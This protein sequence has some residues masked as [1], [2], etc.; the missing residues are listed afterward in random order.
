MNDQ[1]CGNCKF[2]ARD[3]GN[4]KQ[5]FCRLRPPA[6]FPVPMQQVAGMTLNFIG[7]WP[8]V[9]ETHWCGEWKPKLAS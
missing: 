8:P 9:Q 1:H 2:F 4:M 7:Q 6:V 3:P 5:G